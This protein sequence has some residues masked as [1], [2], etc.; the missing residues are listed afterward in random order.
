MVKIYYIKYLNH[1]CLVLSGSYREGKHSCR[2]RVVLH[3]K[4]VVC[5]G[6]NHLVRRTKVDDPDDLK[7]M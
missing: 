1:C 4:N 3:H 2:I 5:L 6:V 7:K